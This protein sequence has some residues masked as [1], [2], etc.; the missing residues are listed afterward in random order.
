VER[1]AALLLA[2]MMR[3]VVARSRL[4]VRAVEPDRG[5][6][7]A[8]ALGHARRVG[9]SPRAGRPRWAQPRARCRA[10]GQPRPCAGS[11]GRAGH[12]G[13]SLGGCRLAARLRPVSLRLA[14]GGVALVRARRRTGAEA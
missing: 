10:P 12:P 14:T 4:R 13:A 2:V 6:A 3:P 7:A 11:G 9:V 5:D 1:E 8:T